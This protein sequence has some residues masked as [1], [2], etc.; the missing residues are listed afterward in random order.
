MPRA[1]NSR[2]PAPIWAHEPIITPELKVWRAV[3]EQAY[4]DAE[5]P[6]SLDGSEPTEGILA[7]RFLRADSPYEA[8]NLKLVCD[9]ADVPADRVISWARRRYRAEQ[10]FENDVECGSPAA[11]FTAG[12]L[13]E[14]AKREPDSHTPQIAA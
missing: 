6:L 1:T 4:I 7:S 5:L 13:Q 12:H 14:P 9:F 8:Q 10:A 3:L 2:T 11:A